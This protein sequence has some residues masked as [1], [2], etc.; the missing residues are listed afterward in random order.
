MIGIKDHN[1]SFS[2]TFKRA[3]RPALRNLIPENEQLLRDINVNLGAIFNNT[4]QDKLLSAYGE[5]I[6]N[7]SSYE[8]PEQFEERL[9]ALKRFKNSWKA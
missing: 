4:I 7:Q 1:A 8:S 9:E 2:D 3:L 5:I 6:K